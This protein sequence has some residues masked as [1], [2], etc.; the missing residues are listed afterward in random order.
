MQTPEVHPGISES[1]FLKGFETLK[2][3]THLP[4]SPNEK[5]R[6]QKGHLKTKFL[7]L[8]WWSSGL[9]SALPMQQAWV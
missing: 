3:K 4:T 7:G 6:S 8:P 9:D 1:G 5:T 2:L